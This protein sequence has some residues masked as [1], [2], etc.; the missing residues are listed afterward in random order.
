MCAACA[1]VGATMFAYEYSGE[2]KG[3]LADKSLEERKEVRDSFFK[4]YKKTEEQA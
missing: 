2:L 3:S 4:G 1:G